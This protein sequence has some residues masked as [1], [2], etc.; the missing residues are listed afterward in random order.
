M[1]L[2]SYK[3][4]ASDGSEESAVDWSAQDEDTLKRKVP[5]SHTKSPKRQRFGGEHM[6]KARTNVRWAEERVSGGSSMSNSEHAKG[7]DDARAGSRYAHFVIN[8]LLI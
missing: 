2:V 3:S 6:L 8:G 7:E 1:A 5:T 4:D